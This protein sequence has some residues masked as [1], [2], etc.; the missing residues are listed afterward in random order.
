MLESAFRGWG[1]CSQGVSAPGGV[2]GLRGSGPGGGVCW[3]GVWFRSRGGVSQHALKQTPPL[4]TESQMP[5][6]T[7]PWPNFVVAGKN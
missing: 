4:L 6:K 1:V 2:S 5:V 3:R 7:L